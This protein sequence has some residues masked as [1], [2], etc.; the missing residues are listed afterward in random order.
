MQ[1]LSRRVLAFSVASFALVALSCS[2][3]DGGSSGTGGSAAQAGAGGSGGS[4][5]SGATGGSG[6]TSDCCPAARPS[7]GDDCAGC[8]GAACTYLECSGIGQADLACSAGTWKLSASACTGPT[9]GGAQ[10]SPGQICLQLAGGALLEECADNPCPGEPLT[11]SCGAD[12]C[13]GTCMSFSGL[14][15]QCNTCPAGEQCA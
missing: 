6:G 14:T 1:A 5:A 8:E 2:D 3:D 10:C 12:I 11:C 9:C 4:G 15:L 13:P 7:D